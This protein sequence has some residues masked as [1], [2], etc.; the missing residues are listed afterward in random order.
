MSCAIK[1]LSKVIFH[2]ISGEGEEQ[3]SS[4]QQVT[5]KEQGTPVRS[6][7][8]HVSRGPTG[9]RCP[10]RLA[11]QRGRSNT[12]FGPL[13]FRECGT[14]L[15]KP[16]AGVRG[17]VAGDIFRSVV[18]RTMAQQLSRAVEADTA[19][20]K[21]RCK[22]EQPVRCKVISELCTIGTDEVWRM[23]PVMSLRAHYHWEV[24]DC[25]AQFAPA[26]RFLDKLGRLLLDQQGFAAM[27]ATNQMDVAV[28][29]CLAARN[30]PGKHD[31]RHH[32]E[33]MACW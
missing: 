25:E 11:V 5:K 24:W 32:Q 6:L 3:W 13:C 28:P 29:N 9:C 20:F 26:S 8:A 31:E 23:V 14:Q 16:H 17:I 12:A 30:S 4:D 1:R 33:R 7:T 10:V 15:Q 21:T 27:P 2:L 18:V 19:R 22:R